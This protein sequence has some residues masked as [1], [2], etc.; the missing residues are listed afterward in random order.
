M[1]F[2][3]QTTYDE[4]VRHEKRKRLLSH[5][6]S[7]P[8]KKLRHPRMYQRKACLLEPKQ[9]LRPRRSNHRCPDVCHRGRLSGTEGDYLASDDAFTV[10]AI[11]IGEHPSDALCAHAG[12]KE[13]PLLILA[14]L[15]PE[16]DGKIAILDSRNATLFVD[17]DL[18]TLERYARHLRLSTDHGMLSLL[19]A[20]CTC[21]CAV[22]MKIGAPSSLFSNAKM[23]L[24]KPIASGAKDKTK[25]F[26][27]SSSAF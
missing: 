20:L 14:K 23:R 26:L 2:Y 1:L 3:M 12:A 27:Y 16:Q 10:A 17:P 6:R 5:P 7:L 4:G 18:D 8:R 22:P 13:L 24:P 9:T 15:N 19:S 25:Y 21:H 11:F